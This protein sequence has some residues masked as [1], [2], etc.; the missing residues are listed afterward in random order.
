MECETG[1]GRDKLKRLQEYLEEL[2][3]V[4]VAF[5]GGVDSTFLLKAAH[6]VLGDRVV[7]VTVQSRSFPGR[8]RAETVEFCERE[9]IRQVV[10]EV[11]ELQ[12]PG[13]AQ[14]PPDRCYLC[15]KQMFR[16]IREAAEREGAACVAE[17]S[18]ADDEGDYRPGMRAI[19]E[20]G[21]KSP[22]HYVGLSKNEIRILSKELNLSTWDKPSAACLSSRFAY[23]DR[24]TKEKLSMV[25]RAEQ[26]LTDRG[27][28]QVR[29]RVHGDG[30]GM[31]ARIEVLPEDMEKLLDNRDL[32]LSEL[33]KCG[34]TYVTQDLGGYQMGSMNHA[35]S[36]RRRNEVD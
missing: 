2:G 4:A 35:L 24:I 9:G 7:A 23:G 1:Y 26:F 27:F 10:C 16:K 18:N 20:L 28:C 17:G 22:L 25:E 6:D 13:F 11:D 5:S 32:I 31:V 29:V 15:K 12:I 30:P 8:E 36:E 34:F 14:N 21:V 19:R 3:S 33:K